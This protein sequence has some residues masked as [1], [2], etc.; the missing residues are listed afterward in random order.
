[1]PLSLGR[2][3]LTKAAAHRSYARVFRF[4]SV[5]SFGLYWMLYFA[6]IVDNT[7]TEHHHVW[8]V[9]TNS[10]N[11]SKSSRVMS[12]MSTTGQKLKRISKHPVISVTSVDIVFTVVSLLAWSFTRNLDVN[13]MLEN[14]FYSY[15]PHVI[16]KPEK[17]VAFRDETVA[18][19]STAEP[20]AEPVVEAI[21]PRKR[22]RPAKNKAA[23]TNGA[24]TPQADSIRQSSR[25]ATRSDDFDSDVDAK[26]TLRKRR[27]D[28]YDDDDDADS[29]Y[30]PD[31]QTE[32]EV[33]EIESDGVTTATD[34]VQ[35]GEATALAMFLAFV[36]GLGHLAAGVLG[37]EVTGA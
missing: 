19:E 37:A 27:A 33:A 36:G 31:P 9:F 29:T 14:S 8:N 24:F 16:S 11:Q 15:L 22:G 26:N 23:V 7:P 32:Q 21:T 6:S 12:G 34:L 2:R 3:H 5:V 28:N 1:V 13:A 20:E 25:R 10:V 17:H 30:R 35:G 4:L 18:S